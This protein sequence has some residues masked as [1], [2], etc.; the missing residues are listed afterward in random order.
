V[1]Q[2]VRSFG[3]LMTAR[4]PVWGPLALYFSSLA[5]A[6]PAKRT[7]AAPFFSGVRIQQIAIKAI[8]LYVTELMMAWPCA[9]PNHRWRPATFQKISNRLWFSRLL[10]YS[11]ESTVS[12]TL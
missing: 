5:S 11:A 3:T 12:L 6:S 9:A 1:A 8:Q 10:P 7:R 2:S 4:G